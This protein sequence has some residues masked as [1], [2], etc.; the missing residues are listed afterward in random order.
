MLWRITWQVFKNNIE[1]N[2]ICLTAATLTVSPLFS[3]NVQVEFDYQL[4]CIYIYLSSQVF[5][6]RDSYMFIYTYT[7]P[8]KFGIFR[9]ILKLH[10]VVNFT[11][12]WNILKEPVFNSKQAW[13]NWYLTT[14]KSVTP[15]MFK[16]V[17]GRPQK[18][19]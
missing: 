18:F 6:R 11:D 14:L 1:S 15:E 3:Y 12:E 9:F 13:C 19:T 17:K 4:A 7:A 2:Q 8:K 16:W 5:P 10:F